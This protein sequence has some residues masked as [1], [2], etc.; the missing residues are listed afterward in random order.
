MR[1]PRLRRRWSLAR[2]RPETEIGVV[3]SS[4]RRS[5]RSTLIADPAWAPDG[6]ARLAGVGRGR[7]A[8]RRAG[9]GPPARLGPHVRRRRPHAE[10][11]GAGRAACSPAPR[12]CRRAGGRH[13]PALDAAR[14]A[15][16]GRRRRR[17]TRSRPSWT[18]TSPRPGSGARRPRGRCGRPPEAKAEAWQ[19]GDQDDEL[20]NAMQRGGHRRLLPSVPD[21]ADRTVHAAVLRRD[22]GRSGAADQR[23]RRSRSWSGCSR[24]APRA[25]GSTRAESYLPEPANAPALRRLVAEGHNTRSARSAPRP[26]TPPAN[27]RTGDVTTS[28]ATRRPA[29]G[30]TA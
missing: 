16:R 2:R 20:P 12:R 3:Q 24:P 7:A 8:R 11:A 13:R 28:P 23:D 14:R 15:G 4:P 26:G 9:L 21:R 17:R 18:A 6:L 27:R 29:W 25:E 10:H 19:L 30:L 1:R 5:S 22:P